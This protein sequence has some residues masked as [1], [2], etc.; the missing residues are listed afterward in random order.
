MRLILSFVICMWLLS[1]IQSVFGQTPISD[2]DWQTGVVELTTG[3]YT[4]DSGSST[5]ILDVD[6]T[7]HLLTVN[8][9]VTLTVTGDG[10]IR[11]LR[12]PN[13]SQ[14]QVHIEDG[15]LTVVGFRTID[16]RWS[17]EHANAAVVGSWCHIETSSSEAIQTDLGG[18]FS[19]TN[20]KVFRTDGSG[21][22]ILLDPDSA[23]LYAETCLFV[24]NQ[25]GDM[26]DWQGGPLTLVNTTFSTTGRS[27]EG[28]TSATGLIT[29]RSSLFSSPFDQVVFIKSPDATVDATHNGFDVLGTGRAFSYGTVH[30]DEGEIELWEP[31]SFGGD[32]IFK[33]GDGTTAGDYS[34]FSGN[35]AEDGGFDGDVTVSADLAGDT[36]IVTTV[37]MGAYERPISAVGACCVGEVCSVTTSAACTGAYQG[38]DTDCDP[39]P[40]VLDP[41]ACCT[42]ADCTILNEIQCDALDGSFGG[43][44]TACDPNPCLDCDAFILTSDGNVTINAPGVYCYGDGSPTFDWSGA[45][46]SGTFIT[47]NAT[48]GGNV[49]IRPTGGDG[50]DVIQM[51]EGDRVVRV[52]SSN[53]ARVLLKWVDSVGAGLGKYLTANQASNIHVRDSENRSGNVEIETSGG[54]PIEDFLFSNFVADLGTWEPASIIEVSG[55]GVGVNEDPN[56]ITFCT[57]VVM[58]NV[59]MRGGSEADE[60][61]FKMFFIRNP[62][63]NNIRLNHYPLHGNDQP[64][65]FEGVEG[66]SITNVFA[67]IRPIPPYSGYSNTFFSI[68]GVANTFWTN[69]M[70]FQ[71]WDVW[72]E[73]YAISVDSQNCVYRRVMGR[74]GGSNHNPRVYPLRLSEE[75]YDN[76]FY[77][78]VFIADSTGCLWIDDGNDAEYNLPGSAYFESC[79]FISDAHP[80]YS[81]NTRD[82]GTVALED[83]REGA[84][85][86]FVSCLFE[87]YAEHTGVFTTDNASNVYEVILE[88]CAFYNEGTSGLAQLGG[89]SEE[90]YDLSNLGTHPRF[91]LI[92]SNIESPVPLTISGFLADTTANVAL[93]SSS[94]AI[95]LGDFSNTDETVDFAMNPRK[96]GAGLDAGAYE[97]QFGQQAGACCN[98]GTGDC[99]I[100]TE[101]DCGGVYLGDDTECD[102]NPCPAPNGACC[103]DGTDC[104]IE[105]EAD[106]TTL[107]GEWTVGADC[108]EVVCELPTGACCLAGQFC[109]VQTED[110][111]TLAGGAY[112][113]DG[114]SCDPNPCPEPTGGCCVDGSCTIETEA[115]CNTA[116]GEWLGGGTDCGQPCAQPTGACCVDDDPSCTITIEDD[117]SGTWQGSGTDCVPNPCDPNGACCDPSDG[118]CTFVT[119]STCADDWQGAG[120][121]CDP[122]P[123]PQP[124]GACC[125]DDGTCIPGLTESACGGDGWTYQGDGTVCDPNPCPQPTGACCDGSSCT[126]QTE[127]D[128]T[129]AGDDYQGDGTVCDPNPCPQPPTT[130][131]CCVNDDPSCFVDTSANCTTADGTYQGDGTT[132]NPNPC[133]PTGA[134]CE[135]D[136]SCSLTT[137]SACVGTWQGAGTI[138]SPNPCTQPDGACCAPAACLLMTE[139]ECDGF[140]WDFQGDET[141][142][143]P[144]PCDTPEGACCNPSNGGCTIR[145]EDACEQLNHVYQGH[146]TVCA[147]NPC[148]VPTGACCD[149]RSGNCTVTEFFGCDQAW[150]EYQGNGTVCSPSPCP[151]PSGVC[152]AEDGS[153]TYVIRSACELPSVWFVGPSSCDPNPCP[154]PTGA[155][156]Q[157]SISGDGICFVT[158]EENCVEQQGAYQGDGT[159]CAEGGCDTPVP[160]GLTVKVIQATTTSLI[161]ITPDVN[162]VSLAQNGTL[163]VGGTEQRAVLWEFV[164]DEPIQG[165]VLSAHVDAELVGFV[166]PAAMMGIYRMLPDV[167]MSEA[168]WNNY[169]A[170]GTWA[171]PGGLSIGDDRQALESQ[172]IIPQTQVGTVRVIDGVRGAHLVK[173]YL[174]QDGRLVL[175]LYSQYN[176]YTWEGEGNPPTMTI[177]YIRS[178]G[179][180]MEMVS[181]R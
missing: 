42:Y 44:N 83:M 25:T 146:D 13:G 27:I 60:T 131:A 9:N 170:S 29:L 49:V 153:C 53:T 80:S 16:F 17:G 79:T 65:K 94:L 108:F 18:D 104:T 176:G 160:R 32:I 128:C 81:G 85:L 171:T 117:C 105:T 3:S 154:Q 36:R 103:V 39:D 12:T 144:D 151:E 150:Q 140:G 77:N 61:G 37:D 100:Q 68:R 98:E 118:S 114:T 56:D 51:G 148:P 136:G 141:T 107:G 156:C 169:N 7:G 24:S 111:C 43:E 46:N 163:G 87:N 180:R 92:G 165:V 177:S 45:G 137:S 120:V 82:S 181:P 23:G 142:C 31:N 33:D 145:A 147:P 178:G 71:D 62:Q 174:S 89:G 59:Y 125:Q 124:T 155:C 127:D 67:R 175:G 99:Q 57:D 10:Y 41:G 28:Q 14:G 134:C 143:D 179:R 95:D 66:G 166:P 121:P 72:G 110:D 152:C 138:C 135:S 88:D 122:N 86:T 78:S 69:D 73:D 93:R 50:S 20:S 58:E 26:I 123:C 158:T 159:E 40:C 6:R 38:D 47:V 168:T 112:E 21:R 1:G 30:Y 161:D 75:A 90:W 34:L 157:I 133:D 173:N 19:F 8:G 35:R 113:G 22:T 129:T 63:W 116:G 167:E 149:S 52:A 101:M 164:L 55:V 76:Y 109:D 132:C 84:T 11:N 74:A 15:T 172:T 70:L 97:Y 130:G 106:C 96:V 91:T 5:D 102:P 54:T 2:T 48:T 162:Y 119:E 115:D 64:A 139:E 4:W 126:L